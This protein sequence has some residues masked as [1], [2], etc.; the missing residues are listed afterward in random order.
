MKSVAVFLFAL[1]SL[2]QF[3]LYDQFTPKMDWEQLNT[4]CTRSDR[5][6][7]VYQLM[8]NCNREVNI[9]GFIT[10]VGGVVC[11]TEET[12]SRLESPVGTKAKNYCLEK[13]T[14]EPFILK[15]NILGGTY[16]SVYEFPHMVALGY[17]KLGK[18]EYDCGG[19]L[20]AENFV[21]TAAHCVHLRNQPVKTVRI[22]RVSKF[23]T[24]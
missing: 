4:P 7:G 8:R 23:Q 10:S 21:I 15:H 13:G 3:D 9:V 18:I 5:K 20:V 19:S 14:K 24:I 11:C 22:G 6:E 2:I 1:I 12:Y 17:E 16:S